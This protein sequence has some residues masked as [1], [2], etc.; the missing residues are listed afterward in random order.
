[1]CNYIAPPLNDANLPKLEEILNK[2]ISLNSYRNISFDF[3]QEEKTFFPF[4]IAEKDSPNEKDDARTLILTKST[5]KKIIINFE[6]C[7]L[8]MSLDGPVSI[9]D[10]RIPIGSRSYIWIQC[11]NINSKRY[12][13]TRLWMLINKNEE[14]PTK[15][16]FRIET[17]E[18]VEVLE[19]LTEAL[20]FFDRWEMKLSNH[21]EWSFHALTVIAEEKM[22]EPDW[23]SDTFIDWITVDDKIRIQWDEVDEETNHTRRNIIKNIL[24][25][26][27]ENK[28]KDFFHSATDINI[29]SILYWIQSKDEVSSLFLL[30]NNIRLLM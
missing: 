29:A 2:K 21:I 13:D 24:P 23:I 4:M 25:G 6:S 22:K 28:M 19:S 11:L 5:L 26:E 10:L 30:Y 8:N 7:L 3:G 1:M 9:N 16:G 17:K 18:L 27:F 20:N 12:L 14:I 15:R